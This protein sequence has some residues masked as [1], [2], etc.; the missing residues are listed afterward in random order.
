[1]G[2][3]PFISTAQMRKVRFGLSDFS[4]VLD[5]DLEPCACNLIF[6]VLSAPSVGI[7]SY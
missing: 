3:G 1:M 5:R 2:Q 7:Y 4:K 6:I